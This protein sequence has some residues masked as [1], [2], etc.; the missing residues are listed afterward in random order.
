[1]DPISPDSKG[2]EDT[3]LRLQ[4]QLADQQVV[5]DALSSAADAGGD[6]ALARALQEE[7]D[8]AA[9]LRSGSAALT[10]EGRSARVAALRQPVAAGALVAE[11]PMSADFGLVASDEALAAHLQQLELE[12][13]SRALVAERRGSLQ[14]APEEPPKI[15][16]PVWGKWSSVRAD[17]SPLRPEVIVCLSCCPCC[18]PPCCNDERKRAWARVLSSASFLLSLAQLALMLASIWASGRNGFAPTSVNSMIGPWPDALDRLGAKNTAR[19]VVRGEV[20]RLVA[21]IMLHAGFIHLLANL[22]MQLRLGLFLELQWG[23]PI[24]LAIYV[25][26]GIFAT[27]GSAL[28]LPASI[29]VGASGALMGVLGAWLSEILVSWERGRE[30]P[31]AAAE[32]QP[33]SLSA[34]AGSAAFAV[35]SALSPRAR[36]AHAAQAAAVAEEE[37]SKRVAQLMLAILNIGVVMAFSL[38]PLIDWAAHTFGLI[39]GLLGGGALFAWRQGRTRLA[40]TCAVVFV[41]TFVVGVVLLFT[42][43]VVL[44]PPEL[45]DLCAWEAAVYVPQGFSVRC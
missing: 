36:A 19:I 38:T 42:P 17:G 15:E 6:E 16:D 35:F 9:Q 7:E 10:G 24:F 26:A 43:G 27:L 33:F 45:L 11:L 39:G 28:F 13:A 31:A 41:S 44:F 5:I 18:V 32:A 30:A 3:I 8:A 23:R 21:P 29:G 22:V 1:M 2:A 14:S 34:T 25:S 20:W 12:R 4:R 37:Q 40:A